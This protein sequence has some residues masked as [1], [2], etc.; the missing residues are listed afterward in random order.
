MPARTPTVLTRDDL[1]NLLNARLTEPLALLAAC[2]REVILHSAAAEAI[3]AGTAPPFHLRPG[4]VAEMMRFYDQLRRQGQSVDRYEELLVE[5]L[6][7]ESDRGA[8]RLLRQTR[9]L[10]ASYRGYE[11][12]LAARSLVDEHVLRAHLIRN[13]AADPLRR[14]VVAVGDWIAD[15]HGLFAAD[16]DLL[17]RVPGLEQLDIV[18]T[19]GLLRSGFDQRVHDWLPGLD[20]IDEIL[21]ASPVPRMLAPD[22]E[23]GSPVWVNRDR[24]EELVAVARRASGDLDRIAVVFARPLPYLYLAPEVFGGARIP[25]QAV[26]TLPLAAEPAAA[27]LDLIIEFVSSQFTRAAALAVLRS[28]QV[29]VGKDLSRAAIAGLDRA[30]REKRYLG[31][32][33]ALRLFVAEFDGD[34]DVRAAGMAVARAAE[35]LQPLTTPAP[36]SSQL[37][38]LASFLAS[39]ANPDAGAR[40]V[41]GCSAL[42]HVLQ[43]LAA[44]HASHGDPHATIDDLAPDIRRWIEE[45]TFDPRG[46]DAAGI[47]LLDAQAARF[48]EFESITIVGL[49]EGEWPE[50]PRRNI[51][52]SPG[53]LAALGWP[54]ERDRRS[55]SVAAFVDLVRSPSAEVLVSTFTF[56]DEAL[57][58]PSSLVEG[59]GERPSDRREG[60]TGRAGGAN[61]HG[62]SALDRSGSARR[63]RCRCT[64]VGGGAY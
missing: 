34:A 42:V 64:R 53:V 10:A 19:S 43:S 21:P 54:S 15:P 17:A 48:G 40:S 61:L 49:I 39:H 28:P 31:E 58:E 32:L 25:Y 50:R 14:V 2:E 45:E 12:R 3:A 47:H 8:E 9:F 1:Y 44:A 22:R 6:D 27:A 38:V 26:D 5:A 30:M 20:E 11:Q 36:A 4:L 37:A 63:A 33:E 57:V 29:L 35:A 51:F 62:R 60:R 18:A 46:D 23:D 16:F 55:A 13:G 59:A 24:E 41:R 56:D 52:Y 7:A